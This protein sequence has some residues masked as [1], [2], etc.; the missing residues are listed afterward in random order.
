MWRINGLA[1]NSLR[2][3]RSGAGPI[4]VWLVAAVSVGCS[5]PVLPVRPTLYELDVRL[6]PQAHTMAADAVIH[7]QPR[8]TKGPPPRR[9]AIELKL[10]PALRLSDIQVQGATLLWH[11][12]RAGNPTDDAS[13][14]PT[15]HQLVVEDAGPDIVVSL[16]YD[17]QLYQDVSAGEVAGQIHNFDMA[18][19]IGL[20]GIYLSG[21]GYWH[22]TLALPEGADPSLG[23]AQFRLTV[24]PI[25]GFELVAGAQR[26]S[27]D[28]G[29]GKLHWQSGLPVEAMVLLGGPF[30]RWTRQH[31][32]VTLHAVLSPEKEDVAADILDYIGELLD[33]Y[34]PLLGRYPYTEF[35]LLEAFFSSGFAFPTCTQIHGS[36]LTADK[37]YRR[38]GYIDH[39]MVHAWWGCGV[40]VDPR[41]GN[42]CEA[43][44]SFC[45]NDYGYV[46]DG[47]EI[48][49]R[50]QRRNHANFLS[51]IKPEDDKPLGTFGLDEGAG[52]GIA[53]GK[54]AAVF[55]MLE[56]TL[57]A[58]TFFG[59][60]RRLSTDRAGSY[61]NWKDLQ[62]AFESQ[63]GREL[64]WFFEQWVHRGG[65]PLLE[66]SGADYKPGSDQLA[67]WLTQGENAFDLAVPLR[68][69]YGESFRDVAVD[70]NRS[71]D[72]VT[73]P[74][75]PYGLTA[76]ELDPD[77]R[78]FRKLKPSAIMPTSSL[79]KRGQ[80]LTIVV[81]EGPLA[82]GYQTV[83]EAYRRAVAGPDDDPKEGAQV[84]VVPSNEVTPE[85]L[86]EGNVLVLGEA[87]TCGAV[88]ELLADTQNPVRWTADGFEINGQAYRD[89][90]Q[91]VFFTVHHP[92]QA[93]FGI[94]V[95]YGNAPASLGNAGLLSYYANSLL[96]FQTPTEVD[97][98]S[99]GA[100]SPAPPRAQVIERIDFESHDRISL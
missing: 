15:T 27:T 42:W 65:A 44:T 89:P 61:V 7:L 75:K 64:G 99:E 53:Y 85:I 66:L 91:A 30:K 47:D 48:G 51:R 23:L 81:P 34:E 11:M 88:V 71:E 97:N 22:P 56:Q 37:P 72:R 63:S 73:V 94:T 83:L 46:L 33:R 95:Y 92:D 9:A 76:V 70:L 74:C 50:K 18:A 10:H 36:R 84:E 59:A 16:S 29:D 31:G 77:Y 100:E 3:A 68:L 20:D 69:H 52:R 35:T 13:V 12:P 49:A 32:E 6:N 19:H 98:P 87:V 14:S 4:G 39:E 45:T 55:G 67:V 96:V 2:W 41:D 28:G 43:L 82:A 86:A 17:G 40:Y 38:H 93:E 78:I 58:E 62:D 79:T 5:A 8:P 90:G 24:E 80:R 57:G 1:G 26:S 60:L 21:A 54:G 25:E